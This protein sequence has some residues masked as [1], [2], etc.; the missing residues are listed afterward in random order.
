[1]PLTMFTIAATVSPG[2][3]SYW[4]PK[5]QKRT[6][7][8]IENCCTATLNS[9]SSHVCY[10]NFCHLPE[11]VPGWCSANVSFDKALGNKFVLTTQLKKEAFR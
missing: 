6:S 9:N 8:F 5:N 2:F 10:L 4:T 7:F 11:Y 3:F 1:M